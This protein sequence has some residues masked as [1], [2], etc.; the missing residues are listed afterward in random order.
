MHR[1]NVRKSSFGHERSAKIQISLR[2]RAVWSESSL[3]AFWIA[4]DAKFVHAGIEESDLT[5]RM[6][7]LIW[8]FGQ[9]LKVTFFRVT[10]QIDSQRFVRTNANNGNPDSLSIC[11]V[12]LHIL[13]FL[14]S[15]AD[16]GR[17]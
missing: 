14:N 1:I 17:G 7:R 5:A 15:R 10:A 9:T 2:I 6:R 12:S 4:K 16:L 11:A 13:Q 8:V 3:D